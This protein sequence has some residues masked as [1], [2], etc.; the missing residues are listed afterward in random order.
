MYLILSGNMILARLLQSEN[1]RA[2]ILVT[3]D[4]NTIFVSPLQSENA[5]SSI[6]VTLSGSVIL[7]KPRQPL[8]ASKPILVTPDGTFVFLQ[9]TTNLLLDF[10]I[11]A[12]QF[13]LLSYTLLFSSTLMLS[14]LL[15]SQN[16]KKPISVTLSGS[17][18]LI[19]PLQP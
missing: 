1:T 2:P 7:V 18:I 14:K 10:S 17:M 6:S 4:G 12:L 16:A 11:I 5:A 13:S 8:N 19:K 15:Q 9:P 3:P